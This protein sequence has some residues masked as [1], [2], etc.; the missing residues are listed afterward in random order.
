MAFN[1][2]YFYINKTISGGQASSGT[3]NFWAQTVQNQ[4]VFQGSSS[5]MSTQRSWQF[6]PASGPPAQYKLCRICG[7]QPR[8]TLWNGVECN[9]NAV[10]IVESP[11]EAFVTILTT[12]FNINSTNQQAYIN[13]YHPSQT[14]TGLSLPQGDG[15]VQRIGESAVEVPE[16]PATHYLGPH[17]TTFNNPDRPVD[18]ANT[19]QDDINQYG[20]VVGDAS[21]HATEVQENQG[22]VKDMAQDYLD[23][24][25]LYLQAENEL[26]ALQSEVAFNPGGFVDAPP[27]DS[28]LTVD[29]PSIN[30]LAGTE[31]FID[32]GIRKQAEEILDAFA[33]RANLDPYFA[34][35][36]ENFASF[37]PTTFLSDNSFRALKR[38]TSLD[39][40]SDGKYR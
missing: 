28:P 14:R 39:G 26:R 21:L 12:A 19:F 23:L 3:I 11:F 9:M 16:E 34:K 33:E 17:Y 20:L 30:I 8:I 5:G 13:L 31:S 18:Q 38:I 2:A 10:S 40:E 37:N 22:N 29:F 24:Y 15:G 1:F 36:T 25:S 4:Y 6:I 7:L 35:D 27:S 32:R